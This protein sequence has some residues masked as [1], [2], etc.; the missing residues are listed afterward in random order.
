V[1]PVERPTLS[2]RIL[3]WLRAGYPQGIPPR[4][5]VALLGVLRRQLTDEDIDTIAAE[6]AAHTD[7]SGDPVTEADIHAIVRDRVFQTATDEDI[8]RV[9]SRL[10][11]GGWPLSSSLD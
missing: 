3:D 9:S 10:A 4:D 1:T 5:Y 8:Q 11:S 6:L 7:A 2:A